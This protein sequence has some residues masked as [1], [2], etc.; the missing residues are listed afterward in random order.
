MIFPCVSCLDLDFMIF[1][2]LLK[3]KEMNHE[4]MNATTT[5]PT[6]DCYK[7]QYVI[8]MYGMYLY[9]LRI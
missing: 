7:L 3:K 2:R 9:L 5:I 4:F 1:I 8:V 6:T